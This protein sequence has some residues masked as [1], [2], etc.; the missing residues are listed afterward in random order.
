MLARNLF[1]GGI[2]I[3]FEGS[4]FDEKAARTRALMDAGTKTI[5]E[6]TFIYD[7]VLV[8]VDILRRGRKGWELYE[9]KASTEVKDVHLDDVAVQY[10]VLSGSGLDLAS[11]S[12]VHINNRYVRKGGLEFD[13]LFSVEDITG[14]A[15]QKQ[16]FVK[17][18]LDTMRRALDN[19]VPKIDIGPYCN[20][21]YECDFSSY[22][23]AHIPENSVFTLS[24]L[25]G[26]KKFE[27][28]YKGILDFNQLPKDFTLTESQRLQVEAELTGKK[29]ID[30]EGIKQ[31]LKQISY[32]LYF[33]DFETF[34]PAV[35]PFDGLRPYEK[36]PF[37]YSLHYLEKEGGKLKHGE[38]LAK[39]GTDPREKLAL[40]LIGDIPE[41]ACVLVYNS[42]FEK[43]V[44]CGLAK[45]FPKHAERLMNIHDNIVDLMTPFQKKQCYTKEMSGSYS[46]KYVLP[47]L[48]PELK[49][50]GLEI[51]DGSE[52]SASYGTLHLT[53][54]K[55]EV[56]RIRKGLL[57]YCKLDTYAM[58]K[59]LEKLKAV[60]RE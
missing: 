53:V 25:N 42:G 3:E 34:N 28:Y 58:V 12:V 44:I 26:A 15:V 37:Q 19:G 21:P 41:R 18:E 40:R 47:A 11:A 30:E 29:A 17:E 59:L 13:R 14:A 35:P 4:S 31:F 24:R 7:G 54:D 56:E 46:I 10:Y 51:S 20:Q 52:A 23:W 38:F 22:C 16:D 27:L 57:E 32:P 39:E 8:M 36:T 48:V 50:D 5:Y 33:L 9:V 55:N 43:G 45:Q 60:G 6:A 49:Y 2:A 1:P